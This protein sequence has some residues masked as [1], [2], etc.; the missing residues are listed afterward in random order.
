[1]SKSKVD[2]ELWNGTGV[3]SGFLISA[4]SL[5]SCKMKE[6]HP[7]LPK[8]WFFIYKMRALEQN[9]QDFFCSGT[10]WLSS[11][12]RRSWS[13]TSL[14]GGLNYFPDAML[15]RGAVPW[16]LYRAKPWQSLFQTWCGHHC[17]LILLALQGYSGSTSSWNSTW[18]IQGHLEE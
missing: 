5:R 7:G 9:L 1:M 15:K 3:R 11:G 8:C 10:H 14:L 2:K 18:G 17:S 6:I 12:R 16:N 4:L 13:L